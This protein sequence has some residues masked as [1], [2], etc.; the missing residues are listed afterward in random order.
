MA[1]GLARWVGVACVAMVLTAACGWLWLQRPQAA[2]APTQARAHFQ[3]A[4]QWLRAHEGDVLGD[5]NAALWWMVS[6]AGRVSAS[7]YLSD[8][9]RRAWQRH[10]PEDQPRTPW[11]RLVQ[12][13]APIDVGE[14]D[15][16]ALLPYQR[17][18]LHAVT[19]GQ[20]GVPPDDATAYLHRN[21][22]RPMV[23][24]VWF[25]DRVCST[26]QL[27]A[28]QLHRRTGCP[29]AQGAPAVAR[30][31]LDDIRT[32]LWVDVLVKDAYVQ[33][34]LMLAW[35]DGP[36]APRAAWVRRVL[37]SQ[38]DDGSWDGRFQLP[39][40]PSVLQP[41]R[42]AAAWPAAL[43]GTASRSPDFH[44]TAQGL[45]LSALLAYPEA[46]PVHARR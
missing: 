42:V 1:R 20:P 33:R 26:H 6:E 9:V 7:P 22:C 25:E 43:G 19:C 46:A 44:A 3:R 10:H 39:E 45:L 21:V 16:T 2:V 12:P 34:V 28:I 41:W 4:E 5:A 8:L 18:M 13:A 17:F 38:R 15:T 27:M 35:V 32:Q 30:S 29:D 31:L 11:R 40:L 36:G 23:G 24:R 14:V 37:A